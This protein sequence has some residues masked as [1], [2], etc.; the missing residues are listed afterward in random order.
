MRTDQRSRQEEK[1]VEISK[2]EMKRC[3]L[4]AVTGEVDS[5][6][7]PELEEALQGLVAAGKKNLVVNLTNVSFMSSAGL[8]ALIGAQMK[9]RRMIP[10]GDVVL[11]EVPPYLKETLELVGFHHVFKFYDDDVEAVGSF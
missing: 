7:A 11:S 6:S 1:K 10:A 9:V 5:A 8:K 4:V 2:T 3:E